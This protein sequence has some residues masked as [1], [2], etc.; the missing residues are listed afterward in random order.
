[1]GGGGGGTLSGVG[2][3]QGGSGGSRG[4]E[5]RGGGR[6]WGEGILESNRDSHHADTPSSE[7][8]HLQAVLVFAI[9]SSLKV[10]AW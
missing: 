10:E 1:M 7:L 8:T 2:G 4:G 3:L 9:S 6:G 5:R